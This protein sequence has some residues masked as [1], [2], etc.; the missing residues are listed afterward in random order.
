MRRETADTAE[1]IPEE[2]RRRQYGRPVLRRLYRRSAGDG[3]EEQ[4]MADIEMDGV[5]QVTVV[6]DTRHVTRDT[7]RAGAEPG[8]RGLHAGAG[9][10]ERHDDREQRRGLGPQQHLHVPQQPGGRPRPAHR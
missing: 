3:E 1:I 7:W 4:E 9:R 10:G 2:T 8:R 6:P 5:I